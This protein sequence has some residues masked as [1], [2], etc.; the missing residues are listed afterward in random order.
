MTTIQRGVK[1]QRWNK[2]RQQTYILRHSCIYRIWQSWKKFCK[3][4]V[5]TDKQAPLYSQ[6]VVLSITHAQECCMKDVSQLNKYPALQYANTAPTLDLKSHCLGVH[7]CT[8]HAGLYTGSLMGFLEWLNL[9]GVGMTDSFHS[10]GMGYGMEGWLEAW[11]QIAEHEL[12]EDNQLSWSHEE[13][14]VQWQQTA[15]ISMLSNAVVS[16]VEKQC[17]LTSCSDLYS[18]S[19]SRKCCL[20]S[21]TFVI[22]SLA[23]FINFPFSPVN[24]PLHRFL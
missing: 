21:I 17:P 12:G 20:T 3:R 5:W 16:I 19:L 18:C 10:A 24:S 8:N 11:S 9:E 1:V 7:S 2:C 14:T 4:G 15:F 22:F 23:L 13:A 6:I